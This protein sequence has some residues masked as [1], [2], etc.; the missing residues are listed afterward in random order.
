MVSAQLLIKEFSVT[1]PRVEVRVF[2]FP[3]RGNENSMEDSKNRSPHS[4]LI[5]FRSGVE[6]VGVLKGFLGEKKL[7]NEN[8]K[9]IF[10]E[11]SQEFGIT[12]KT[13]LQKSRLSEQKIFQI[14]KCL[15]SK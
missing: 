9:P 15:Y 2:S 8:G 14:N 3:G 6:G 11:R 7:E 12:L 10:E 13:L 1:K 5:F 4:M